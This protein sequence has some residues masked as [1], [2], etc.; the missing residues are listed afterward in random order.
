MMVVC[1]RMQQRHLLGNDHYLMSKKK[2]YFSQVFYHYGIFQIPVRRKK[3]VC[4]VL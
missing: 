2:Q 3:S 1:L 4:F